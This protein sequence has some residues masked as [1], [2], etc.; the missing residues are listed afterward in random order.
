MRAILL[1]SAGW[2]I[3]NFRAARLIPPCRQ[4]STI[5]RICR[6]SICIS[7]KP[8]CPNDVLDGIFIPPTMSTNRHLVNNNEPFSRR[9]MLCHPKAK[10]GAIPQEGCGVVN[11]RIPARFAVLDRLE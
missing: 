7:L 2:E 6:T 4:T 8:S 11:A 3:P 1:L 5:C 9:K 10:M